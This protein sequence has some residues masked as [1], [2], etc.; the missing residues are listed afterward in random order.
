MVKF[1]RGLSGVKSSYGILSGRKEWRMAQNA[2]PSDQLCLK[3]FTST[4][5]GEREEVG[6]ERG[7]EGEVEGGEEE[8]EGSNNHFWQVS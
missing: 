4:F 3:S 6:R 1:L 8:S 7:G 2:R 5:W